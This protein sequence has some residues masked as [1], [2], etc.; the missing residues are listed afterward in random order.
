MCRFSAEVRKVRQRLG[1]LQALCGAGVPNLPNLPN[2]F[3]R[4]RT[5]AR[6]R[7]R[8]H[9]HVCVFLDYRLGRLGR[10]GKVRRGAACRV[11]NLGARLG[12]LGTWPQ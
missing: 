11:P 10:L 3:P 7:A 9:A 8:T 12:R 6:I 4:P 1:T 5:H 2:L